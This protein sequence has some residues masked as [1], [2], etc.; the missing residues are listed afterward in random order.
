MKHHEDCEDPYCIGECMEEE[1]D[2]YDEPDLN[3]PNEAERRET[4]PKPR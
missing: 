4:G 1:Y 3:A 2:G